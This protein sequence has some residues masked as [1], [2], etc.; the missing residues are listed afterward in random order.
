MR[1]CNLSSGLRERLLVGFFALVVFFSIL[2][3]CLLRHYSFLNSIN[4]IGVFDQA[5][6][7]GA[8]GLGFLNTSMP[9][10]G[11]NSWLG[12]HFHLI[13]GFF[14]PLYMIAESVYW[15]YFVQAA[16][17]S[18]SVCVVYYIADELGWGIWGRFF[19]VLAFL[20]NPFV[21]NAFLWDFHPVFIALPICLWGYVCILKDKWKE[22]LVVC[23]LLMLIKESLGLM[24]AG[25]GVLAIFANHRVLLGGGLV[26]LGVIHL[27]VVV[28]ILMPYY[29]PL[30]SHPMLMEGQGQLSRF[31]WLGGTIEE[32]VRYVLFNPI[33]VVS[34]VL[35]GIGAWRYIVVL[36]FPYMFLSLLQFHFLIP[37]LGELAVNVLSLN[38]MPRNIHSYH[39]VLVAAGFLV[40]AMSAVRSM[41][42][43]SLFRLVRCS[44]IMIAVAIFFLWNIVVTGN[45]WGVE[46][47]RGLS[48]SE[49]LI[50][51]KG[52]L[53]DDQKLRIQANLGGHLTARAEVRRYEGRVE[54]GEVVILLL[55]SPTL[56]ESGGH[57]REIATLAHHL[58]MSPEEYLESIE[59]LLQQPGEVLFWENNWL[60]FQVKEGNR[61][62]PE[63]ERLINQRISYLSQSWLEG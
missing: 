15:F 60:V 9:Y 40:A 42:E 23:F 61:V 44:K 26:F 14:V 37:V 19:W 17:L 30:D 46:L 13:L 49:E 53:R 22:L 50:R 35:F 20:L 28:N 21:F 29:S 39:S 58:Q 18:V 7:G 25:F 47:N 52:I 5:V 43:L 3:W 38:G 51:I 6:W 63:L 8:N 56:R 34:F 41:W 45:Y 48:Q 24:V 62:T 36:F 11:N 31:S 57:P 2:S 55:D 54:K 32:I 4:D 16:C 27:F 12:F 1:R 33:E 59:Q 10:S